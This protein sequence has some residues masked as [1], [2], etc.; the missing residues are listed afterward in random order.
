MPG[1]DPE[2]TDIVDYILRITYRIWEGKQVG[3]CRDFYSADC[4]V[5]T[6]AGYIEGAE[7]KVVVEW[8]VFD[9]LAVL[10][11]VCRARNAA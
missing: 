10:T 3:L 1:F 5:Y 2:F 4:P 6:L 8:L 11:Q 7:D 9:E